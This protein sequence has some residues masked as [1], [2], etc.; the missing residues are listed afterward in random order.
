MN[1]D[2]QAKDYNIE[3]GSVLHLVRNW[4]SAQR[5]HCSPVQPL[6]SGVQK[7]A[8]QLTLSHNCRCW[9]CEVGDSSYV[10]RPPS[11]SRSTRLH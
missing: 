6:W 7:I 2:K 8:G 9:H 11:T 3:G 10:C 1:D 5:L 4:P